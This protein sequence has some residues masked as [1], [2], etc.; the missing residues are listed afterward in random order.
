MKIGRNDPCH[1]GSGKKYKKCHLD[2][3]NEIT[4][5]YK[6]FS[7]IRQE[8]LSLQSKGIY[9]NYVNPI[10]FKGGKVWALGNKVYGQRPLNETFHDFI[11]FIL[12][13]TL[14]F[15]WIEDQLLLQKDQRHYLVNC[16]EEFDIWKQKV[17]V[18]DN[19]LPGSKVFSAT[20]NGYVKSMLTL[21]FDVATLRHASKVP[22][23]LLERL[24]NPTHY[25]GARYEITIA[26]IMV[27]LGFSVEWFDDSHRDKKHCEFI[28]THTSSNTKIAI[29]VKSRH[30][31]GVLHTPGEIK[32]DLSNYK[33]DV[34]HLINRACEKTEYGKMPFIIFIDVNAPF[35]D[36]TDFKEIPWIKDILKRAHGRKP[37]TAENPSLINATYFTN[38]SF[39]YQGDEDATTGQN[40]QS[41]SNFH[42]FPIPDNSLY[43][44]ILNALHYYGDIP[45]LKLIN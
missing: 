34:E 7:N 1:C 36:A 26:G 23:S 41:L 28:A 31:Q 11:Q 16:F 18:P 22:D 45:D 32:K 21:A 24:R 19:L 9:I 30:R 39:H 14:G 8:V 6:H 43:S 12:K 17:S 25:Q 3:D 4:D 37:T 40:L 15:Q 35:K 29:E 27:R 13:E 44:G 5:V 20:P 42:K 33:G 38:F 10:E 2:S